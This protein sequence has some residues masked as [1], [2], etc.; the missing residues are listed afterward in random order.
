MGFGHTKNHVSGDR[1]SGG[2]TTLIDGADR[3]VKKLGNTSWFHLVQPGVIRNARRGKA[4][5]TIRFH[6]DE[7][8]KETLKL[9]FRRPGSA[10][11]V[12]LHV[13]GLHEKLGEVVADITRVVG[14]KLRGIAIYDRTAE[15]I[16]EDVRGE[17]DGVMDGDDD[18][19]K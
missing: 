10:Q 17:R 2:H 8:H 13:P 3:V 15:R 18:L 5:V 19:A 14:E 6:I 11:N 7:A 16:T 4:S 9:I 1:V 12:Y